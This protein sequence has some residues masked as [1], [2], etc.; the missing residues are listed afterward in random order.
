MVDD[1]LDKLADIELPAPPH[2]QPLLTGIAAALVIIASAAWLGLRLWRRHRTAAMSPTQ[3]A[4]AH[5]D[6]LL[7]EWQ[8]GLMDDR[9]ASYRLAALLRLGLGLAQLDVHCPTPLSRD[10]LQWS[11]TVAA[12]QRLRYEA[13]PAV[14]LEEE[15]FA[16]IKA[17]IAAAA[18]QPLSA[19]T[20][21][22]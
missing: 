1:P 15:E 18:A 20:Q 11:R 17:W 14:R 12:L 19:A 21:Q 5:I 9:E 3:R 4:L 13:A 16:R 10:K 22:P 7:G 8:R 2:W 6:A